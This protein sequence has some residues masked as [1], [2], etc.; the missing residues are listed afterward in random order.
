MCH[1]SPAVTVDI[2]KRVDIMIRKNVKIQP[3]MIFPHPALV[4]P[5][6]FFNITAHGEPL[7]HVSSELFA[8]RVP[9]TAENFHALSTVERGFGY[10]GFCF[11]RMIPGLMC[12]G[13]DFT[14][15]NGGKSIYGEKFN[16]ENTILKRMSPGI[17]SMANAGP[18]TDGSQ[19]PICTAKTQWLDGK[20]VEFGQEKDGM[21]VV[22][23]MER[24]GSSN[25]KTSKKVTMV[26]CGQLS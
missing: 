25:G 1:C 9:K 12:Q 20:H 26:D 22:A 19:F 11:H 7:G 2:M 10:K 5:T 6:V 3:L 14:H 8:D 16:D 24:C 18:N 17:L 23:A 21:G 13:G 15:H 4:N